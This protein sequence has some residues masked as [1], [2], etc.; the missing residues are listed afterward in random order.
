MDTYGHMVETLRSWRC[1]F[2]GTGTRTDPVQAGRRTPLPAHYTGSRSA[3]SRQWL[4]HTE[5]Y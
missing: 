3:H 1:I 5:T 2:L 4:K